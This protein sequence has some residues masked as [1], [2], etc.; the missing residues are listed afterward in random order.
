MFKRYNEGLSA[1][2][3]ATLLQPGP[4]GTIDFNNNR[5]L[6]SSLS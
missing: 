3:Y 1:I 5:L 6:L 2:T 4:D